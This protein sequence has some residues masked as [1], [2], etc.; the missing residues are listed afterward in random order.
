MGKEHLNAWTDLA[1]EVLGM[2]TMAEESLFSES[3]TITNTSALAIGSM[4]SS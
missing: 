4:V 1:K 3:P 2:Q